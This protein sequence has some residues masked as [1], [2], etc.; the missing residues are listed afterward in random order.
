MKLTDNERNLMFMRF[1]YAYR[2]PWTCFSREYEQMLRIYGENI[3]HTAIKVSYWSFVLTSPSDG[4]LDNFEKSLSEYLGIDRKLLHQIVDED[5]DELY[6]KW[7][8]EYKYEE[9]QEV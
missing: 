8:I 9:L 3:L 2:K 1:G 7:A 6:N 4:P 5:A